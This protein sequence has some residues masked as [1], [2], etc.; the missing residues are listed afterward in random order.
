LAE[1]AAN[2]LDDLS[3]DQIDAN[4]LADIDR[5]LKQS[6]KRIDARARRLGIDVDQP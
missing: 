6:S 5:R 3:D 2:L 1:Q 4:E